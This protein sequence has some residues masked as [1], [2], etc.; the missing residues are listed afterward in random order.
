MPFDATRYRQ[1]RAR[2]RITPNPQVPP[3]EGPRKMRLKWGTTEEPIIGN[4][5]AV[6]FEIRIAS[7]EV[8]TDGAWHEYAID[9]SRNRFWD[10]K[11]NELWFE[12]VD[13]RHAT[14]E[15]DW[16]RFEP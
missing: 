4:C 9:L 3:G 10:G 15:I 14:V 1:F 11:V 16:M 2:M 12:G 5:N 7:A 6:D 8:K 13:L